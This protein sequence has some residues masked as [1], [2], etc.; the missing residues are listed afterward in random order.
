M[1]TSPLRRSL[2]VAL[3]GAVAFTPLR[4]QNATTGVPAT[5][6]NPY[7]KVS[8]WT[9][10]V[11]PKKPITQDTYDEWR[12]IQGAALSQDGKWA[13]Y[14][15]SPVVGEG[16]LVVRSTTGTTEYR[17]PRGFTG[18]P[19]LQAAAD[20]AALFS[21]QPAQISANGRFVAFTQYA[22]RAEIERARGRR[23]APQP[24]S[25][26]GLLDVT[27]GKV[28]RVPRVRSFRM[29]RN[30]GRSRSLSVGNQLSGR[31]PFVALDDFARR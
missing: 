9:P 1:R 29:A 8:Q 19:Q 10:P 2:T 24:P 27:D 7:T 12:V 30:G 20:S 14:T 5:P 26:M 6:A 22:S 25:A 28:L 13:V 15:V 11:S 23:A 4:A 16:E 3:L 31:R 18:R 21:P 17:A